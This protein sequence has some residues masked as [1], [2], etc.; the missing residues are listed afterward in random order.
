MAGA[1]LLAGVLTA[2]VLG[3][4]RPAPPAGPVP[5]SF[6]HIV[7]HPD[8]DLFF[9]NPDIVQAMRTGAAVT[10]V[11][12]TAAEGNGKNVVRGRN[13]GAPV[14]HPA[15]IAARHAGVRRA[16]AQMATG[17]PAARWSRRR[18][19]ARHGFVE[20]DTL[21]AR[22]RIALVF[23]NLGNW[24]VDGRVRRLTDLWRGTVPA[25]ATRPPLGGTVPE[26]RTY[27]RG[28][29]IAE[30]T[31]LLRRYRPSVV[32]SLDPD[33]E[34]G[35]DAK[36]AEHRT[37]NPDHTATALLARE[38]VARYARAG[39]PPPQVVYYRG[40]YNRHWP[41][42]LGQ[43]TVAE[44]LAF[45]GTYGWADQ[46]TFPCH[47]P[48]GC[49]DL[50]VGATGALSGWPQGTHPRYPGTA[51]WLRPLPD[52]RLAAFAVVGGRVLRWE[53]QAPGGPWRPGVPLPGDGFLPEVSVLRLPDGR[54]AVFGVQVVPGR[55]LTEPSYRVVY[56]TQDR[57]SGGFGDWR[58][59]GNP[60]GG[61]PARLRDVGATVPAVDGAGRISV[62]VRNGG[63]GVSG[64]TQRADGAFGPW[65]DLHGKRVQDGLAAETDAAGRI[66]L[67]GAALPAG[68]QWDRPSGTP[69]LWHWRQGTP[70]GPMGAGA[71]TPVTP[72]VT[73]PLTL[74]RD[75]G[76][77][78]DLLARQANGGGTV[79][80]R[81]PR[82]AGPWPGTGTV[83]AGPGGYGPV[84]AAFAG[85][86]ALWLTGR[87]ASGS[88]AV[89]SGGG[90][91]DIGGLFLQAPAAAVD[92]T[93]RPVVA[94]IDT[95][96]RLRVARRSAASG[97]EWRTAG[98][99]A[100]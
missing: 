30:L 100:P 83:L 90:W 2:G 38:A 46:G 6:L 93:G 98:T 58:D 64:R 32:R 43:E 99:Q 53:E 13:A 3:F 1:L 96:G 85:G 51:R 78:L 34:R 75:R 57:P 91:Q 9:I 27:T 79:L 71:W 54:L 73:G 18:V 48:G 66:E 82:P 84:G 35:V 88:A 12:V 20:I 16:Y 31:W 69:G 61:A 68:W 39:A 97:W 23:L 59:L 37:D 47:E 80:F 42:N 77:R 89:H 8:D 36:G 5:P 52:G 21:A 87:S 50:Q 45:V 41:G 92:A 76:G 33:P 72:G 14:D 17:D 70:G 62:F 29:L 10:T 55:T 28:A 81:R 74:V 22:R 19:H 24:L 49:G 56:A 65:T 67:F 26:S 4:Q 63:L 25:L 11:Y 60:A 15:Y 44:K 95:Q 86:G 94:V 7:A 40:Y